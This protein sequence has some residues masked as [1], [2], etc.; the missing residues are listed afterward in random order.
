MYF[1]IS[2]NFAHMVSEIEKYVSEKYQKFIKYHGVLRVHL[3]ITFLA[4]VF[5]VAMLKSILERFVKQNIY[6]LAQ[7]GGLVHL[8]QIM[9]IPHLYGMLYL[10]KF[11]KFAISLEKIVF[12]TKHKYTHI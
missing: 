7:L 12:I 6:E 3:F 2:W 5:V 8:G 10:T 11:K 1:A 4:E 9:F